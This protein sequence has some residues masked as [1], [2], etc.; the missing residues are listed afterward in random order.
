MVAVEVVIALLTVCVLLC[1]CTFVDV[2]NEVR[3]ENEIITVNNNVEGIGLVTERTETETR[4]SAPFQS[5]QLG[6]A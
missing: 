3:T 4:D 1:T 6:S 2:R 5:N